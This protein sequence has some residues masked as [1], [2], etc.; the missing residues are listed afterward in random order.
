M[1]RSPETSHLPDV[2]IVVL[3]CVR[4]WD[5]PDGVEGLS[6]TPFLDAL[7]KESVTFPKAVAVAPWT[8]PSHATLFTGRLPWEHGTHGKGSLTLRKEV[9][10]LP[11]LLKKLGYRTVSLSANALICPPSGLVEGFDAAA[12]GSLIDLFLRFGNKTTPSHSQGLGGAFEEV[13]LGLG[14]KLLSRLPHEDIPFRSILERNVSIPA[15][16]GHAWRGVQGADPRD[17]FSVARWIE[18]T[19][20]EILQSTRKD[21][22]LFCFINF[23]DAHEP[24]FPWPEAVRTPGLIWRSLRTR[25]DRPGWLARTDRNGS[26]DLSL[27]HRLYRASIRSMDHR[28][29]RVVESLQRHGRWENSLL[30]VTSD[31]GQAFGEKGMIYHRFRVDESMIRI[32]LWVRFPRSAH[33]NMRAEGWASLVDVVPTVLEAVGHVPHDPLAGSSL[34]QL[35]SQPRREPVMAIAD[36]T[37]GERWIPAARQEELDRVSVAVFAEDVKVTYTATPDEV[38]AYEIVQDPRE[39]RDVWAERRT[40]LGFWADLAKE[41]SGKLQSAPP[42]AP[43]PGVLERLQGWGY[44]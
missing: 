26:W 28:I 11:Q 27:L 23:C 42:V 10:R 44:V 3:D 17:E 37:M 1:S 20:E 22:P 14:G 36:G 13:K 7:R 40:E 15:L 9:P 16:A 18:P 8:I 41:V 39:Q 43:S 31:H 6:G 35:I 19:F 4:A 2:I 33:G 24:Y 30:V 38:H 32:P 21:E 25:Q 5:F 12:W 34:T 29:Q